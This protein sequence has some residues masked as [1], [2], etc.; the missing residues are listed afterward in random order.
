[1]AGFIGRSVNLY[2]G[3]ESPPVP[4]LGIRE[5]GVTIGGE[6]ID[7]TSGEDDGNRLLLTLAAQKETNISISGIVKDAVLRAL[8]YNANRTNT[9][10]LEYPDGAT[11][12]GTFY[13]ANHE[14]TG[15]YND[16]QTFSGELQSSGLVTYTP[17][18]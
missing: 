18:A 4:L 10:T 11:I 8:A 14:E 3:D 16:A 13:Y 6:P 1:M 17:A 12:S 15:P 7:V 2:I 9:F 5:K